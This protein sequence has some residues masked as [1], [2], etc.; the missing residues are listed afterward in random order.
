MEPEPSV[1]HIAQMEDTEGS[2]ED[3]QDD[4]DGDVEDVQD[5]SILEIEPMTVNGKQVKHVK[6]VTNKNVEGTPFTLR[7]CFLIILLGM[8]LAVLFMVVVGVTMGK[9]SSSE[10]TS[11]PDQSMFSR[12]A[13]ATDVGLCSD[14]GSAIL[15]Q[16]GSAVDAAI[17]SLLCVGVVNPQSSG[18][19]GG[20]FMLVYDKKSQKAETLMAR[21]KAPAA[22]TVNMYQNDATEQLRGYRSVAVPGE[23]QGMWEAHKVYG[24]LPWQ[25]LFTSVI[26]LA[27]N[28]FPMTAHQERALNKFSKVHNITSLPEYARLVARYQTDD[29]R[30]KTAGDIVSCPILAK[31]LKAISING[32]T[33]L[34]TG[35]SGQRL[36]Q[37]MNTYGGI[38][39]T[40]DMEDYTAEW[41][42]ASTLSLGQDKTLLT[43]PTPSG[44][45]FVQFIIN[46]L[47]N[48]NLSDTLLKSSD[49]RTQIYHKF[50]EASKFAFAL[51]SYVGDVDTAEVQ[52]VLNKMKSESLAKTVFSQIEDNQVTYTDASGY[53]PLHSTASHHGGTCHISVVDEDGNAVSATTTVNYHF[54]SLMISNSTGILWNNEMADFDTPV[55]QPASSVNYIE[56]GKMPLS[57]MSP[58]IVVNEK[59]GDVELV[60]GSAGSRAIITTNAWITLM[61][62]F[63]EATLEDITDEKRVHNQLQPENVVMYESG[64]DQDIL[65]SLVSMGHTLKEKPLLSI[66]QS[67]RRSGN[68]WDAY[69]DKRKHGRAAGY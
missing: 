51:R 30:W 22:A 42:P 18:L 36:I 62:V 41:M 39:T 23:L 3:L 5:E 57:A 6:L 33:E 47:S 60:T 67:I 20:M 15:K 29:G 52:E 1:S 61:S 7:T 55:S 26:E 12:A 14:I 69:S 2:M 35:Q 4:Q 13:V 37:E 16:G 45:P 11:S 19:G 40:A 66:V 25:E 32:H 9:D 53:D 59:S 65:N 64:L 49:D 44:G 34:S 46:I 31:T 56:P 43:S 24:K 27:E 58:V 63:T 21:E 50:I 68:R 28:G 10:S 17:S 38:L 8:G 48:I 54:G